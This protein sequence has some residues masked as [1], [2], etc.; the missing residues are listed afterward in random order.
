M[1][2]CPTC[3][4]AMIVSNEVRPEKIAD[5][6][7]CSNPYHP[8][9]EACPKCGRDGAQRVMTSGGRKSMVQCLHCKH[10]WRPSFSDLD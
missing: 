8:M 7:R 2:T 9:R 6:G 3:R 5:F 1:K 10:A 4:Y